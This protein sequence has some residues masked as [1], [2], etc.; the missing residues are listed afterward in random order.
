VGAL[1]THTNQPA[2]QQESLPVSPSAVGDVLVLAVEAKFPNS[3]SF[4]AATVTGGGVGTWQKA[5]SYLTLDGYHGLELWWGVVTQTG[6]ST[7]T[8]GY[9]SGSTSGTSESATSLDVQELRA[10][11]G[12]A[13]MWAVDTRGLVDTGLAS[14]NPV[15]P[16]LTPA[17]ANEAYVGYLA[18]PGWVNNGSTPGVTYQTDARGNQVVYDASVSSTITP[19]T[20]S[21]S[22]TFASIGL[23]LR[24]G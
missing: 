16:T 23:L 24:A 12:A 19:S 9:T 7:V 20:T 1:Q 15:Y 8:V 14:T 13:T 10:S 17:A 21:N 18:I 5:L 2:V 22:Q 3:A 6:A 11:T 4:T